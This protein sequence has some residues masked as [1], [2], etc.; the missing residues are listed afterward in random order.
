MG[1]ASGGPYE[2]HVEKTVFWHGT[3]SKYKSNKCGDALIATFE[4][5][6]RHLTLCPRQKLSTLI[7]F[8]KPTCV[9]K[10]QDKNHQP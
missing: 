2:G 5:T 1:G 4:N 9:D 6:N 3:L 10:W 7:R 8:C